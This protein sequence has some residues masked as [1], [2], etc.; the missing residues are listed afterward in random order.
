VEPGTVD[1]DV[2]ASIAV[3]IAAI[4]VML[5]VALG[6]ALALPLQPILALP[7][8]GT[9]ANNLLPA[10][11]G[12]LIVSMLLTNDLGGNVYARGRFKGL[13]LSVA[14]LVLLTC[15]DQQISAFLYLDTLLGQQGRGVLMTSLQGFVIMA[16][17][18]VTYFSTK[19]LYRRGQIR[20]ELC[21]PSVTIGNRDTI[22]RPDPDLPG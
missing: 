15:F 5:I 22:D 16:I 7:A 6:I 10:V 20:V 2:I 14:L 9:A 11:L 21:E 8:V 18:P 12:S 19:W 1:A 13:V 4:V 3:S 17:L